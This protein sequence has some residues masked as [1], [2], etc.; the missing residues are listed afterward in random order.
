M[1]GNTTPQLMFIPINKI[2]NYQE[3][4]Y[5]KEYFNVDRL[6]K[7]VVKGNVSEDLNACSKT[8][9]SPDELCYFD[10]SELL[11][12]FKTE[13]NL[14][15]KKSIEECV[16]MLKGFTV[17]DLKKAQKI[18]ESIEKGEVADVGVNT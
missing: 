4:Y 3:E 17:D 16:K 12:R 2:H 7:D 15:Q 13:R 6:L 1:Y 8:S 14:E 5:N 18:I 11:P 9:I 10:M